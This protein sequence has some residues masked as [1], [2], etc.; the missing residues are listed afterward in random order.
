MTS[1]SVDLRQLD[2]KL[3][4]GQMCPANLHCMVLKRLSDWWRQVPQ[5]DRE[6]EARMAVVVELCLGS[7][8]TLC[9]L[10]DYICSVSR[11]LEV[12]SAV[13]AKPEGL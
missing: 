3:E 5:A 13:G 6:A 8:D 4:V 2:Q 7:S 9:L 10:G 11:S 12:Y 1:H